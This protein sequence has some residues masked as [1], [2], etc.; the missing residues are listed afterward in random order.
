MCLPR[1]IQRLEGVALFARLWIALRFFNRANSPTEAQ[2]CANVVALRRETLLAT[3][4]IL[5]IGSALS[6]GFPLNKG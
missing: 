1:K 6:L 2:V 4:I 3:L 5:K